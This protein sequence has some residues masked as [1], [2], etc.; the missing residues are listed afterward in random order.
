MNRNCTIKF[1]NI[2]YFFFFIANFSNG[3]AQSISNDTPYYW[4]RLSDE[5][6]KACDSAEGISIPPEDF[7]DAIAQEAL[8]NCDAET[9]YYGFDHAPDYVKARQ[10]AFLQKADDI[11]AM[12]YANGKGVHRNLDLAL[13]FACAMNAS[14]LAMEVRI[15]HLLDLKKSN[16]TNENFD[17]CDDETSGAHLS[18]CAFIAQRLDIP[19]QKKE[20]ATL[21]TKWTLPEQQAFQKLQDASQAYF[22]THLENEM[23]L[24]GTASG[25]F[26]VAEEMSLHERMLKVLQ[27]SDQCHIPHY[28]LQQFQEADTQLNNLYKKII[29]EGSEDTGISPARIKKTQRVWIKY[30]DAWAAFGHVKCPKVTQESWNTL[31]TKERI[32]ELENLGNGEREDLGLYGP[33]VK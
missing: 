17:I 13:H 14:M 19:R 5:V 28:T 2:L 29:S 33:A 18:H 21:T 10:C 32:K 20:L 7:P 25:M 24:S 11:L 4:Q 30:R 3:D 23:D 16:N 27:A 26:V 9:L 6:K 15:H 31:I 12:I 1:K 8:K 22:N